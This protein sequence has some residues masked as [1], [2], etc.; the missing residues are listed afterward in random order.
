MRV[1]D[2]ILNK[3][4]GAKNPYKVSM[5]IG[6]SGKNRRCLCYDGHI[7]HYDK[8]T[9]LEVVSHLAFKE[10]LEKVMDEVEDE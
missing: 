3:H 1:G 6:W 10:Q 2:I 5:F 8:G 7:S 9:D 4:A